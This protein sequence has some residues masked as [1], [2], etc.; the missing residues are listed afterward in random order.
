ML[1]KQY[2]AELEETKT[3]ANWYSRTRGKINARATRHRE[4]THQAAIITEKKIKELELK[5]IQLYDKRNNEREIQERKRRR[6]EKEE[7]ERKAQE[8][9]ELRRKQ[10]R[11][12]R[13][14]QEE[15]EKQER[16]RREWE[17]QEEER[18]RDFNPEYEERRWMQ[19]FGHCK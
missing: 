11:M 2:I 18:R 9:E 6:E 5:L 15:C 4:S 16:W 8:E 17:A 14:I 3:N 12:D 19:R 13:V 7:E 1:C 10:A